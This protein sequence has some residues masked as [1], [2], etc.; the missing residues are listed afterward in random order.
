MSE[1]EGER[2]RKKGRERE[3]DRKREGKTRGERVCVVTGSV[4]VPQIRVE[5]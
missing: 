2:G 1:R 5:V 3:K 4:L